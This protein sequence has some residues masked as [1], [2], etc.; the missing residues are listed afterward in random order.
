VKQYAFY[1]AALSKLPGF[2]WVTLFSNERRAG[3]FRRNHWVPVPVASDLAEL[4]LHLNIKSCSWRHITRL[5]EWEDMFGTI[6]TY[7][8]SP[9]CAVA[10]TLSPV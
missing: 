9:I 3:Y 5:Y 6:G 1:P 8:Q 2:F 4:K 7:A 10:Y